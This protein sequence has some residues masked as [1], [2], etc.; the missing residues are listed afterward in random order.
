MCISENSI[1]NPYGINLYG[2]D[3]SS[4][5]SF[6]VAG[7]HH[8]DIG[9]LLDRLGIAVRTG[10]HGAQPLMSRLNVQGTVRAS[11]AL[12]NTLEEVDVFVEGLRRVVK[13]F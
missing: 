1:S 12:Y 6:N 4:V 11:F 7:I 5:V 8:L 3:S 2:H 13:M 9:T 10:H